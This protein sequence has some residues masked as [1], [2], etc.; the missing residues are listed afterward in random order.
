MALRE[1]FSMGVSKGSVIG[2][3]FL[4]RRLKISC[5]RGV[6]ALKRLQNS[7]SLKLCSYSFPLFSPMTIYFDTIIGITNW[8]GLAITA[9][10]DFPGSLSISAD[11]ALPYSD[12]RQLQQ[13][14][15]EA[16]L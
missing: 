12:L 1:A 7:L 11:K 9:R 6:L 10:E 4:E 3:L 16:A 8:V 2:C 15:S 13:G 14:D 5:S